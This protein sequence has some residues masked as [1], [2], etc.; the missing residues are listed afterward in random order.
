MKP[1]LVAQFTTCYFGYNDAE[2][3]HSDEGH[4]NNI[5]KI[6]QENTGKIMITAHMDSDEAEDPRAEG[7]GT[8]RIQ[9]AKDYLTS[10]GIDASRILSEDKLDEMPKDQSGTELGQAKN[11]RLSFT[12]I[13]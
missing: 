1:G 11:R 4:L 12:Y 6:L 3:T 5:V 7:I 13:E 9:V 2:L 10:K 8:E